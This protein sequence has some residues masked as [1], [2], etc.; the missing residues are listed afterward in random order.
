MSKYEYK[1]MSRDQVSRHLQL[2]GFSGEF[3]DEFMGMIRN[4]KINVLRIRGG[5][6]S[7]ADG[8]IT[9]DIHHCIDKNV[10]ALCEWIHITDSI[11][12]LR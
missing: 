5:K 8:F 7:G 11:T 9:N 6:P 10:K 12:K 3:T 1:S 2:S 4:P